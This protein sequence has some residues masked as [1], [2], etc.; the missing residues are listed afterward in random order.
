MENFIDSIRLSIE[1]ENWFAALFIALALPDICGSIET[2]NET[3]GVRYRRWYDKYLLPKYGGM[4]TAD[5]CY[6]F[7][8]ACLHE[9]LDKHQRMVY[10]HIQFITPPMRENIVHCNI[11]D[12]KLQLQIDVFCED[13][14]LAVEQWLEDVADNEDICNR[15]QL[16]IK[17]HNAR[18]VLEAARI[19][20]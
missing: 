12:D 9:G 11:I 6:Y 1:N 5:D 13:V 2:P 15:L 8:C 20:I 16:L 4:F 19:F 17:I 7:R 10:E 14:R 3:V 18:D